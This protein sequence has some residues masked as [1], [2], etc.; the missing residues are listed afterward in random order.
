[1]SPRKFFKGAVSVP[2]VFS[3]QESDNVRLPSRNE[4]YRGNFYQKD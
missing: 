4:V 3:Y 2:K 1:M